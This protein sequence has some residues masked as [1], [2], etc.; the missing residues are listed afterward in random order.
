MHL[1]YWADSFLEG[2][3]VRKKARFAIS[4]AGYKCSVKCKIFN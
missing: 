1:P 2:A 4:K 3:K